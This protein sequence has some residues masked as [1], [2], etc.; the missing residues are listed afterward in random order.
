MVGSL[1]ALSQTRLIDYCIHSCYSSVLNT[2]WSCFHVDLERCTVCCRLRAVLYHSYSFKY[3]QVFD[4]MGRK[5]H[6]WKKKPEF[7]KDF[8]L[9]VSISLDKVCV[10]FPVSIPLDKVSIRSKLQCLKQDLVSALPRS[11]NELHIASRFRCNIQPLF[12]TFL[13]GLK[14]LST[15]DT[16][17]SE[18][19]ISYPYSQ[20]MKTNVRVSEHLQQRFWM[21]ESVS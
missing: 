7:G 15:S 12:L 5:R 3:I 9:L 4:G 18:T 19:H 21:M 10:S 13:G 14:H 20:T 8:S 17:F 6:W 16:S 2:R 1:V 11:W